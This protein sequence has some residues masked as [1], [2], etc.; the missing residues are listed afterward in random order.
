MSVRVAV[1]GAAGRMGQAVCAAVDGAVAFVVEQVL[2]AFAPLDDRK[3]GDIADRM[4]A[5]DQGEGCG[6]SHGRGV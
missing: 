2:I 5:G 6:Q 4:D 3:T 1:A